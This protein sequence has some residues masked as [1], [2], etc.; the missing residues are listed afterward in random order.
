MR[1]LLLLSFIL[2][3]LPAPRLAQGQG[4]VTAETLELDSGNLAEQLAYIPEYSPESASFP[5]TEDDVRDLESDEEYIYIS[6]GLIHAP[7]SVSFGGNGSLTLIRHD[8]GEKITARYRR[9]DGSYDRVEL[10]MLDQVMHCSLTGRGVRM[11]LKLIELL[12]AIEDNFGRKGLVLL[13]G[14]RTPKNNHRTPGAASESLHMLG[15]AAD[16]RIPGYSSTKV[17]TFARKLGAGGVGYYP[18]KGFTHLDVGEERYWVNRRPTRRRRA[19]PRGK[20]P[21]ARS[22][23]KKAPPSRPAARKGSVSSPSK[24]SS[25]S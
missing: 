17:K 16:I 10:K 22:T 25:R 4:P 19:A 14:Y 15:W 11:S 23:V 13:S 2:N 24:I 21:A 7:E 5:V 9:A 1:L 18:Y 3:I 20:R 12:D 6:S 8:N